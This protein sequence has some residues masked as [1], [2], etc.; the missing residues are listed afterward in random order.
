[1]RNL[2]VGSACLNLCVGPMCI[3]SEEASRL[4]ANISQKAL[5]VSNTRYLIENITLEGRKNNSQGERNDFKDHYLCL[6]HLKPFEKY[7][8][9][10][11]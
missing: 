5:N 10:E 4:K 8:V 9:K 2:A 11:M 7:S 1:M 6:I 3:N